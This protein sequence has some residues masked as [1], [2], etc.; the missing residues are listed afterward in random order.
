MLKTENRTYHKLYARPLVAVCM[1]ML[2]ACNTDE[3]LPSNPP[4]NQG[5][6]PIELTVG[7]S[8][9]GGA[10]VTRGTTRA[11][12]TT[13]NPY[14]HPAGRLA[15]GTSLYM[16]MKSEDG[17]SYSPPAAAGPAKYV[18]TIGFAQ[19]EATSVSDK[20]KF[21]A[22]YMRYYEDT[23]SRES[24]VSV[25]SACVPGYYYDGTQVDVTPNGTVDGTL[26]TVGGS[27][28]YTS[29]DWGTEA[30]GATVAWPLRSAAV[31][32][33]TG[34]FVASQDLC[35]SNNVSNLAGNSPADDNRIY[36]DNVERKFSHKQ[37]IFYHALTKVTFI[38]KKGTGFE[39]SNFLFTN[40]ATEN[41]VL[42]GFNTSGTLDMTTGEFN[43]VGTTDISKLLVRVDNHSA[44]IDGIA[45]ELD[46]LMLP[47]SDLD[48][49]DKDDTH[50]I[51]FTIDDNLYHV[52]K[53]QLAT[54]L[55]GKM[56][57][58]GT[59]TAL[60]DGNEMRQ[61]VHYIF[62]LTVGK[63]KVEAL[64]ASVVDW[65]NVEASATPSN[66]RI[67]LS[68]LN[69]GTPVTDNKP[70]IDLFRSANV[71]GNATIR[72]DWESYDWKTGYAPTDNPLLNKAQLHETST[73]GLYYAE[74]TE[75]PNTAWYWPNNR[76][77]Y[78][79]RMV[80]PKT[81]DTPPAWKVTE[82]AAY[83]D[84]ITLAGHEYSSTPSSSYKDVCW[85]APFKPTSGKLTYDKDTYGFDGT[86][87]HQIQK[88]IGPT[89]S[90]INIVMFHMMSDVTI[91]LTTSESGDTD[92]DARVDLD[93]ATL[94]LSSICPTGKVRMGN[95]LVVADGSPAAVNGTVDNTYHQWRYGFVPQELTDVV[96][97]I[98]TT[99][100]NLYI[101]DMKDVVAAGSSIKQKLI[102]N[103][104]TE[105]PTGSGNYTID[106]WY[107]NYKYTYTFRLTKSDI[108]LITATLAAW[109][110]VTATEQTVQIK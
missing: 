59:T 35:F 19:E 103:P 82:D 92:Y 61:G 17:G 108:S 91:K 90:T 88:A 75:T 39:S 53:Q 69:N 28:T 50:T 109:E 11:V 8:G 29:N 94:S 68:F 104:Y 101:V 9:E 42:K 64:T 47:G 38:I 20:V 99:D 105:T 76:T 23:Y 96:L 43:S 56:L 84:Y 74:E 15:V 18:R 49:S 55:A 97:T 93:G 67:V 106:R 36:F 21:A 4:D 40:A 95:G 1:L 13:D 30:I 16:V 41:I 70:D 65:E 100:N 107:P 27:T 52:T 71:D 33:Q 3:T 86:S 14:G 79:F 77:F 72:D 98:K 83:G 57:S 32:D 7:I 44:A 37:M 5:K 73:D 78:H 80:M 60:T 10:A 24:K 48:G 31:G 102:A 89:E 46:G 22:N 26:W 51:Y 2:S 81:T 45:Y 25:Y 54:A 34:T 63:K 87:S 110:D 58:N 12:V 62:T 85:G 6:T 66:A